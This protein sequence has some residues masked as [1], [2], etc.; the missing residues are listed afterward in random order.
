MNKAEAIEAAAREVLDHSGPDCLTDRLTTLR[1]V[2]DAMALGI[3]EDEIRAAAIAVA[4][5]RL[6]Q[7]QQA[8]VDEAYDAAKRRLL[9]QKIRETRARIARLY[10]LLPA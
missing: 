8:F 10:E 6:S 1:A 7:L 4:E 2:D 3:T 5:G 9:H